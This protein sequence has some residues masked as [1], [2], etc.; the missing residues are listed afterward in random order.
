MIFRQIDIF[1]PQI[2]F[3]HQGICFDP[4][5]GSGSMPMT[6]EINYFGFVVFLSPSK[7]I[8][9]AANLRKVLKQLPNR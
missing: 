1:D 4:Q 9:M 5:R 7:F 3:V 6:H 2:P 8:R